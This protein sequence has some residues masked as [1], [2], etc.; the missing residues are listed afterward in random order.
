MNKIIQVFADNTK[1]AL[2]ISFKDDNLNIESV[3]SEQII[4]ILNKFILTNASPENSISIDIVDFN[5]VMQDR[6]LEYI[7]VEIEHWEDINDF[8]Q[9]IDKVAKYI[10]PKKAI[11]CGIESGYDIE[12]EH[13]YYILEILNSSKL[14]SGKTIWG[15]NMMEHL[16]GRLKMFIF[17]GT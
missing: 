16:L 2:R 3:S 5:Y 17:L 10:K 15:I 4:E 9:K 6:E 12:L 7:F 13:I 11:L 1:I 8:F 14:E